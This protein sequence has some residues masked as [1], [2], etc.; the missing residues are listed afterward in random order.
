MKLDVNPQQ[1]Q[2]LNFML[3]GRTQTEAAQ[4]VNVSRETITRWLS[5]DRFSSELD[6]RRTEL[7]QNHRDR[8]SG[9]LGDA[10]AEIESLL[11]SDDERIRLDAAKTIIRT[12]LPSNG[13][14]LNV[15]NRSLSVQ[16]VWSDTDNSQVIEGDNNDNQ[17]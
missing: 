9:L 1:E 10:L 16:F 13:I 17:D 4:L 7:W 15:D 8:L 12:A 11:Q 2:V 14:N 5:D 3:S 6:R